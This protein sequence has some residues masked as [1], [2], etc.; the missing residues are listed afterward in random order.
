MRP[1]PCCSRPSRSLHV[2]FPRCAP[3]RWIRSSPCAK[4]R[5]AIICPLIYAA[6][7]SSLL[8]RST[9]AYHC[10]KNP[11]AILCKV[12]GVFV[13]PEIS[14]DLSEDRK[15]LAQRKIDSLGRRQDSRPLARRQ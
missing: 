14:D 9:S 8:P 12:G 4:N 10:H 5:P 15:D 2:S 7:L 11:C 6:N 1:S 3:H 13:N